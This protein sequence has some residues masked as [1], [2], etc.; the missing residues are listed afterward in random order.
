MAGT[1]SRRKEMCATPRCGNEATEVAGGRRVCADCAHG[2]RVF[3][4]QEQ[5]SYL[6]LVARQQG[7]R[8][9]S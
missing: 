8:A 9:E 1:N 3:M 2:F 6:S 7:R 5:P 4:G